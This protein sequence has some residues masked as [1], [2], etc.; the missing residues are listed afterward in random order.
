MA[1]DI[2]KALPELVEAGLISTQKAEDIR[3]YYEAKKQPAQNRLLVIFSILGAI[4]VGL[5]IILIIAHNWDDLSRT[6]KSVFAFIPLLIGQAACAYVILRKPENTAWKEGASAFLIFGVGASISLISQIYNIE[7][8]LGGF[9]LLWMLLIAPLMYLMKSSISSLLFLAGITYY[10]TIV[11]YDQYPSENAWPYWGLLLVGLPYYLNLI[12]TQP[13]GNFTRFHHWLY[14]LSLT[15]CLGIWSDGLEE[16][17]LPAYIAMFGCLYIIGNLPYFK[18]LKGINNGYLIIGA[19]GSM[20]LLITLSFDWFWEDLSRMTEGLGYF[21]TV[22]E[23][24]LLAALSVFGLGLLLWSK[25]RGNWREIR[26]LE[27]VFLL[28]LLVFLLGFQAPLASRILISI[29]IL[30]TGLFT[31]L[32]GA[33]KDHLGILNYG[34]LIITSLIVARFFDQEISFVIR[35]IMFVVVGISFFTANYLMIKKRKQDAV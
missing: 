16:W 22:Q 5:G 3:L 23:F 21:Y 27:I 28:V 19:L 25:R 17:M 4:L 1:N 8:D 34:L 31:I 11:G 35:G 12:K 30:G 7:G 18:S 2:L 33:R 24:W 10:A 32:E 14:P 15:I 13:E 9:M 20:S 29:I 26:P 6:I